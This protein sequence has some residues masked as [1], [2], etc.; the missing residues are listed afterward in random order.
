M[1]EPQ[2]TELYDHVD[3]A[4][5]K[6]SIRQ[7]K[8]LLINLFLLCIFDYL[9]YRLFYSPVSSLCF[10]IWIAVS[11]LFFIICWSISE[12]YFKENHYGLNSANRWMQFICFGSGVVIGTGILLI[13][14]NL[15]SLNPPLTAAHVLTLSS[16]LYMITGIICLTYL[17]Q[18]LR[19]FFLVFL[20]TVLPLF[21]SQFAHPQTAY[22]LFYVAYNFILIIFVF[23]A[24]ASHRNKRRMSILFFKNKELKLNAEE[25]VKWTDEL[26]Q[27]LQVEMDKSKEIELQLQLHN[28]L[29]EQKVKERTYDIEKMNERLENNAQNLRLAHEIAGIRPWHWDIE[30]RKIELTTPEQDRITKDWKSHQSYL[31]KIIHPDDLLF[32]KRALYRHLRGYTPRFDVIMR[33]QYDDHWYWVQEVGQVVLR[34]PQSNVPL[35]MI[36]IR[37]DISQEKKD[38]DRLKLAASVVQ[39]AAEGIFV[40]DENLCY[41]DANPCYEQLTGFKKK[42]IL[43]KHLFDITQND[44]FQQ[45]NMHLNITKQLL[46]KGEFDGELNENFL[47]GKEVSIWTHIN[48]V[49]NDNDQIINYIGIVSDQTEKKRQE[50]R[51]SYLENYDTLTDLPNRFYYNY[52]LHQYLV[53]QKD[54]IKQFA[55]IRFNIDRFRTL[56]EFLTNNGGDELLKK[57]AQRLRLTTPEALLVAHLNGDDFAILYEISHIRPSIEQH[58]SRIFESFIEPFHV[59]GHDIV[60]TV[61]MG[62]AYYPEHGRQIDSLNNHAEQALNDAKR[63]GGNTVCYYSPEKS[64]LL[65]QGVNIERELRNA[66]KNNELVVYYQPKVCAQ[67]H[68]V[69]GFE[70]LARWNHPTRGLIGPDLFIPIA[71]E[72]SLIS[73]IGRFV[74][75]ETAKQIRIWDD[76]GFK[77]ICVSVNVVAQQIHRGQLLNDLDD[78]MQYYQINGKKLELE[79]TESSLM[80]SS[81]IV[82]EMLQEIKQREILI[83]LDDFGT[84]YSS[85]AYL[86]EYPIDILK[87]DRSFISKIGNPKQ[88]A[89][90]SAMIAMGKAMNL[91]LVAEGVETQEQADFLNQQKC[92]ILQGFL[93]SKPLNPEKSTE[94]LKTHKC[95]G[96]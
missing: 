21:I 87:I 96:E 56:N 88:E 82:Q 16:V 32:V 18:S 37:R 33:I 92:D 58:C 61:S 14:F 5:I 42:E 63:L 73:D 22:S 30:H 91:T 24:F 35:R 78:A 43:G 53:S 55:V 13:N 52:Q 54:P 8:A 49:K 85:L 11:S 36:G 17:T 4:H 74:I 70:A 10:N 44:K 84:G 72:T 62:V 93:F 66:I 3:T 76:L 65:T 25:Q 86:T 80:D 60:V 89:I 1:S 6:S 34:H 41:V 19:L 39:Q 57:V 47:S 26:Y 69:Y 64:A 59:Q 75:M 31:E 40:L 28:Q 2:E 50:Q 95:V 51:L 12:F 38:Q 90:V 9:L 71:Q 45:K 83:S 46:Q 67:S 94:F 81:E 7:S 79:I 23:S 20:P 48:A 29:L 15:T 27:Q 68:D 77:N